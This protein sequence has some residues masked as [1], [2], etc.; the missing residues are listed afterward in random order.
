M[1]AAAAHSGAVQLRPATGPHP[2]GQVGVGHAG[3]PVMTNPAYERVSD[4]TR[5]Q[6]ASQ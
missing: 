2:R 5:Q 6:E 3:R 4:E 1:V